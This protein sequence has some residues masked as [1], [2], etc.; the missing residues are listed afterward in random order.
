MRPFFPLIIFTLTLSYFFNYF[1]KKNKKKIYHIHWREISNNV[2]WARTMQ[3]L[4]VTATQPGQRS[5]PEP[6]RRHH[7]QYHQWGPATPVRSHLA[8]PQ[9][10][11]AQKY[12]LDNQASKIYSLRDRERPL[13]LRLHPV[14]TFYRMPPTHFVMLVCDYFTKY[15]EG[16]TQKVC[17]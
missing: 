7:T 15:I 12:Q 14:S 17:Q 2:H 13:R 11:R 10:T 3:Q 8:L 5:F 9:T 1:S 16:L 4:R 6:I